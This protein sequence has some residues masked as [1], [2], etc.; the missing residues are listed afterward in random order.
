[1]KVRD[2]NEEMINEISLAG[3]K[4]KI[5][6]IRTSLEATAK[7]ILQSVKDE[8]SDNKQAFDI[9]KRRLL[10]R[11][12]KYDKPTPEEFLQA[13]NQMRDNIRMVIMGLIGISPGGSLTLSIALKMA[14]KLG[15]V[16]APVKT[17]V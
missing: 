5:K 14:K 10:H 16:L 6:N 12:K 4:D 1:M 7:V 3:M 2:L 13:M 9:F 15:I 17:F 8:S 11:L